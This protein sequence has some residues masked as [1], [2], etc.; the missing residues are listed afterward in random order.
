M[1][2]IRLWSQAKLHLASEA[3]NKA[4][5]GA[6]GI[7]LDVLKNAKVPKHPLWLLTKP[8]IIFQLTELRSGIHPLEYQRLHI[9]IESQ[10]EDHLSIYTDGSK[11]QKPGTC[12][13]SLPMEYIW[14]SPTRSKFDLY[15][16]SLSTLSCVE[17]IEVSNY[18]GL[19]RRLWTVMLRMSNPP[20]WSETINSHPH[21]IQMATWVGWK[22]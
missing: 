22:H 4:S 9:E 12:C 5:F 1:W 13:G 19:R 14:H 20:L 8:C 18:I 10:F 7:G 17:C 11:D 2:Q 21:Q 3:P 15:S 16:W 6:L